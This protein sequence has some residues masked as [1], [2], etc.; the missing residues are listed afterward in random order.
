MDHETKI[1]VCVISYNPEISKLIDTLKSIVRQQNV[2]IQIVISDDGSQ[3]NGFSEAKAF[4]DSIGFTDYR[5]VENAQNQ[6]TVKN[7]ES[8]LHAANGEYVFTTSPG[9]EL[10]H[11]LVLH[12][13]LQHL[14]NSGYL[15]SFADVI[16]YSDK[17]NGMPIACSQLANP[18]ITDVYI[19]C[20]DNKCRWNYVILDDIAT[21]AAILSHR[22]ITTRYIQRI[23]GH[24]KFAE[25]NIYRLM[26]F[27]GIVGTYFPKEVVYYEYGSGVSTSKSEIWAKRLHDDWEATTK[28]MLAEQPFGDKF[29]KEMATVLIRRTHGG[30]LVRKIM[31]RLEKGRIKGKIKM[32]LH[33]R[34]TSTHVRSRICK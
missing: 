20:Q 4:L 7:V 9:D 27:D 21:G 19:K 28:I 17:Y 25:D 14:M 33:K 29:Q 24:V 26:M 10:V 18:Q 8:A 2:N 23:V 15:W 5:F 32:I 13:W 16:A 22:D 11:S 3:N 6:G 1:S 34:M 30:K 12:E 31:R